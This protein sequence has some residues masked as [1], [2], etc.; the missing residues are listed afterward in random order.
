MSHGSPQ[1]FFLTC[2]SAQVIEH[3]N[4]QIYILV[5]T[6]LKVTLIPCSKSATRVDRGHFRITLLV[7]HVAQKSKNIF[8]LC[9]GFA[10]GTL[11]NRLSRFQTCNVS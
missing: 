11:V 2:Y 9:F 3:Y 8:V 1:F 5:K 10:T 6:V 7:N 4:K